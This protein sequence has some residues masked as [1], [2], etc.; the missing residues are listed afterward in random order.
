MLFLI[1]G[2]YQHGFRLVDN[3]V[4]P[5]NKIVLDCMLYFILIFEMFV[6]KAYRL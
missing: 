2:K 4:K 5:S 1:L 3:E 6:S